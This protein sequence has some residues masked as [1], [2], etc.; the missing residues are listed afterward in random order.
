[1]RIPRTLPLLL[2]LSALV[3]SLSLADVAPLAA[4]QYTGTF[5]V[6]NQAGGVITFI[7]K[8]TGNGGVTGSLASNGVRYTLDARIEDGMMVGQLRSSEGTLFLEAERWDSELL[9]MLYG[10]DEQ[11]QLNYDDYSEIGFTLAA[12]GA[13]SGAG[14]GTARTGGAADGGNP[15]GGAS[16]DPYVGTFSDG[17]VTLQLQGGGGQYQGQVNVGG[18]TYP[19]QAQGGAQGLQGVIQAPDGQYQLAAQPQGNG[20]VV[21]S[22]GVQYNLQRQTGQGGASGQTA[23]TGQRAGGASAGGQ[24]AGGGRTGSGRELAPGFT[25]DHA[26]VREWVSFLAG[27][28]LTRMSSYTSGTAGGYSARTDLYLCSDRSFALRDESSVSVDVGGAFGNAGEVDSS[29]GQWYVITNGQVIGLI[30]EARN[31]EVTEFRME[32]VNQETYANGER[33]YVT[34]AEVCSQ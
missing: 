9:V 18:V 8:E 6:P 5:T 34:P 23:G 4:Q 15:L 28:K 16:S 3:W 33:A 7:L 12:V 13:S 29:Q 10:T 2:A 25:E 22:G 19:V 32:Y 11:G 26:D 20:L 14:T 24:A 21:V 31:G 17:N 27:K 30:L 1:M